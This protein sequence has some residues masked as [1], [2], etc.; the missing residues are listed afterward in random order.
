MYTIVLMA[1]MSTT[2][3]IP[4]FGRRC[5]CGCWC[6]GCNC[7]CFCGG[8]CNRGCRRACHCNGGWC[9]H[10]G[11]YCGH[12]CGH[13]CHGGC[14]G[15]CCGGGYV[16]PRGPGPGG[17]GAPGPEGVPAPKKKAQSEAP[18]TLIVHV[19]SGARL[20]IDDQPTNLTSER[21]TFVSPPLQPG[22][23]YAYT[24][25]AELPRDGQTVTRRVIVRA[26]E[27]TEVRLEIPATPVAAATR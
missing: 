7:G 11:H 27:Q 9:G 1:A 22:S 10:C 5:R 19:P 14:Y 3:E 25:R 4:D 15:G 13:G 2:P 21:R 16:T 26:G 6:N 12:Y 8:F 17:P 23:D 24:L 20:T 18:A